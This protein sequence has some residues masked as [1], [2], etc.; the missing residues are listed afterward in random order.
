MTGIEK[1]LELRPRFPRVERAASADDDQAANLLHGSG[2]LSEE[3]GP[4]G[5]EGRAE[6]DHPAH[7]VG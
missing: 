1:L 6:V 7:A 4:P 2:N 5:I 3:Q